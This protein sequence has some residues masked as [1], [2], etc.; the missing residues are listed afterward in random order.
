MRGYTFETQSK[1]V[2]EELFE[3]LFKSVKDVEAFA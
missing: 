1:L 2:R 3:T